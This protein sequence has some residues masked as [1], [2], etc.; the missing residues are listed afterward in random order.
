MYLVFTL[1]DPIPL[2]SWC[3]VLL[4]PPKRFLDSSSGR[5]DCRVSYSWTRSTHKNHVQLFL[6]PVCQHLIRTQ[7]EVYRLVGVLKT[8]TRFPWYWMLITALVLKQQALATRSTTFILSIDQQAFFS[9]SWTLCTICL[10]VP[11]KCF[12]ALPF[13]IVQVYNVLFKQHHNSQLT[14][15]KLT[16]QHKK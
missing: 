13:S 2:S 10:A 5:S 8:P 1:V 9:N 3:S 12:L 16:K 6:L 14:P 7:L 15:C 4:P 11:G